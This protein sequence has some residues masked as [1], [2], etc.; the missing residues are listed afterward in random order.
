M[1]LDF[2]KHPCDNF[3]VKCQLGGIR[4]SI[5]ASRVVHQV[6]KKGMQLKA[7]LKFGGPQQIIVTLKG[8]G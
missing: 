8:V 2:V 1:I 6:M 4:S 3:I 7:K 5:G